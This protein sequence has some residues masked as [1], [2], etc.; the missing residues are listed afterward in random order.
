MKSDL[1]LYI[2]CVVGTIRKCKYES[3]LK[4][5]GFWSWMLP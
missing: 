2:G 3:K 1:A 5:T 4:D